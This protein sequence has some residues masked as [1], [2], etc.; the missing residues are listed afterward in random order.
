MQN[1]EGMEKETIIAS[2]LT[3]WF[4]NLKSEYINLNLGPNS[5]F[6]IWLLLSSMFRFVGFWPVG[7]QPKM[8]C[9]P[10]FLSSIAVVV[11]YLASYSL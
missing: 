5:L 8:G 1:K 6:F 3:L 9:T 7:L 2:F 11:P 4:N 10:A